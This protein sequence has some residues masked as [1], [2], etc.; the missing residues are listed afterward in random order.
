MALTMDGVNHT[1]HSRDG[2]NHT[3]HRDGVNHTRDGADHTN[4]MCVVAA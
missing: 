1:N 4:R 3:N 2:V